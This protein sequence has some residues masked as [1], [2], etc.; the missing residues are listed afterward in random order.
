[1]KTSY[2]GEAGGGMPALS[3]ALSV[4]LL[5]GPLAPGSLIAGFETAQA[6]PLQVVIDVSSAQSSGLRPARGCVAAS[7]L[8]GGRSRIV[9]SSSSRGR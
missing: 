1:M 7:P 5:L 8:L 3:T 9:S 2:G 4:A 6:C